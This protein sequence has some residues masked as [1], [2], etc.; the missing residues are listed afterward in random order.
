MVE[1]PEPVS[2]RLLADL[3]HLVPVIGQLRWQEWG[4][5]PEPED[6]SW[7]MEVTGREAGRD[8]LPV[9]FVAVDADGAALG[10]VGLGEFD[11][12]ELQ[13][14][15]PWVLGLIVRSDRRRHG[16][17]RLLL[18]R[19]EQFAAD[20]GHRTVWVATGPAA[21]F[22]RRCGWQETERLRLAPGEPTTV[23]RKSV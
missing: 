14:R 2:V 11:L 19:L 15:S 5:P 17:G 10:A 4:R 12:D 21:D 7:W 6:P 1:V 3:P 13:D 22:Y 16:I 20:A 9:T 18:T 23:L 8:T